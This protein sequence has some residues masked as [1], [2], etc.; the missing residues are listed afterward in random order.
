MN[1]RRL[2]GILYNHR[3]TFLIFSAVTLLLTCILL[4]WGI[5]CTDFSPWR[6]VKQ[7]CNEH[8]NGNAIGNLCKALCTS[9]DINSLTCQTFHNGKESVFIAEWHETKLVFKKVKDI[10]KSNPLYWIDTNTQTKHYPSENEFKVMIRYTVL[11]KFN[12]SISN[13]N[14]I[15][16][17]RLKPSYQEKDIVKRRN[18]M[19]NAWALLQDHE[20]LCSTLFIDYDLFP[21]LIGTCGPYFAVEYVE[22]IQYSSLFSLNEDKEEWSKQIKLSLLVLKLIEEL[23]NTFIE[24]FHL[25]DIKLQHFGLTK[26]KN[27]LKFIDLDMVYPRSVISRIISETDSCTTDDQCDFFDCRARCNTKTRKCENRV[28]NN[29]LQIVCEK[30]FLGWKNPHKIIV[31]G[32]L[33]SQHT[34]SSLAA[35]LRQCANPASETTKPREPTSEEVQSRLTAI[36]SEMDSEIDNEMLL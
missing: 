18:E 34:P 8:Q 28:A 36:L 35:V 12:I 1:F 23:E 26:E 10:S 6:Y 24:P 19:M 11:T 31:P 29:N 21:Q 17:S 30:I 25:C 14:L 4:H 2:P 22:P 33:M 3:N 32:L 20:Y 27:R 15:R 9:G 16:L 5:I 13:S 7:V